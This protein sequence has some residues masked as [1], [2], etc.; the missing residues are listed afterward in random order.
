[1]KLKGN[2]SNC[3][4]IG[5]LVLIST[6]S[7]GVAQMKASEVHSPKLTAVYAPESDN[8]LVGM[9]LKFKGKIDIDWGDGTIETASV[10]G[11]KEHTY[12]TAGT[13][14]ATFSG[15][16][17]RIWHSVGDEGRLNELT[18]ITSWGSS[19]IKQ[20][21]LR[22]AVRLT[23]V[24]NWLPTTVIS[25]NEC[26]KQCYTFNDPNVIKWDTGNVLDFTEVFKSCTVFNQPI[27]NWD[28]S[29]VKNIQRM[30]GSAV[31]F[32]QSLNGWNTSNVFDMADLFNAAQAF[33]GDISGWDTSKVKGMAN[34]FLN[35]KAFNQDISSWNVAK[36]TNMSNMFNSASAF[37]QDIGGWTTTS[38]KNMINIFRSATAFNQNISGWN[39]SGVSSFAGVF[40]GA[41]S[42]NS[43][44][45]EWDVS[46]ATTMKS[47]FQNASAFNQSLDK[48]DVSKVENMNSMF[49]S[50]YAFNGSL[51]NWK[52]TSLTDCSSMF[53][54][55]HAFNQPINHLDLSGC[56]NM[57]WFLNGA[58]TFNQPV[59]Q[60]D[61][62]KDSNVVRSLDR[63]SI[64]DQNLIDLNYVHNSPLDSKT[65][66]QEE[67]EGLIH[68]EIEFSG[69]VDLTG[70]TI[71]TFGHLYYPKN[72]KN[73]PVVLWCEGGTGLAHE[74]GIAKILAKKG[75]LTLTINRPNKEWKWLERFNTENPQQANYIQFASTYM[76]AITYLQSRSE[77]NIDLIGIGGNSY[78]GVFA[79][80]VSGLDKRVKTG[81]SFFSGGNHRLGTNLPQ[82]NALKDLKQIEIFE[83]TGDG[84]PYHKQR[85]IPFMWSVAANDNWFFFPAPIQTWR[86]ALSTEK[87]LI[88]M[89]LWEH[90]FP[91]N[92]DKQIFNWFD[93]HLK[94]TRKAYN[95]PGKMKI[96]AKGKKL[97]AE[98][99]WTG[100][101][102]VS[103]SNLIVSYGKVLSWHGWVHRM[104]HTIPA[105]VKDGMA[106]AEIPIVEKDIEILVFAN[107]IDDNNVWTSTDPQVIKAS[108]FQ[109]TPPDKVPEINIF[110]WGGIEDE[111]VYFFNCYGLMKKFGEIDNKIVKEGKNSL[112]ITPENFYRTTEKKQIFKMKLYNV[113]ARSH[114]LTLWAKADKN[115]EMTVQVRALPPSNWNKPAPTA[116]MKN[117][118]GA[119]HGADKG[120]LPLYSKIISCK[121]AWQKYEIDCPYNGRPVEGYQLEFVFPKDN[122]ATYWVD[123][124]SFIP[125][126]KL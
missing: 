106:T 124:I 107:V 39:V 89:P 113:Y 114:K 28:T 32:N 80:L 18:T 3:N 65:L 83:K 26:F 50:A 125:I 16:I 12:D 63:T 60:L 41:K 122:K 13:Y 95:A 24:P 101:N 42:F 35:A 76:R 108:D 57:V 117:M 91:E 109:L 78:G 72:G 27:G 104:Y 75:Y 81:V 2:K 22:H 34:M 123:N 51:A 115:V 6:L 121:N 85:N 38:L 15:D 84:A 102:K 116:I 93:I 11:W 43:P 14:T 79:T 119:L 9:P 62:S 97:I 54:N 7:S 59:D 55:A 5:L 126:W 77:A 66:S 49:S 118:P 92:I 111:A 10:V 25:L 47:M 40:S 87:R 103:K 90:G 17:T 36:V 68:E 99:N 100:D 30:F 46:G 112:K 19:D 48:W 86:D 31:A 45:A 61:A 94:K 98:W 56:T 23:S 120:E 69:G 37:N 44:L 110:P 96:K 33:N 74:N 82:F 105:V 52:T 70:K 29:S 67:V 53:K 8:T 58:K 1:M 4:L 73:L 64:F 20:I 71:R 21:W 88:I